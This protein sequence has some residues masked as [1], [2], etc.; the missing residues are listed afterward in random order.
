MGVPY[1]SFVDT[2]A[3]KVTELMVN[4]V[5]YVQAIDKIRNPPNPSQGPADPT[6]SIPIN[7]LPFQLDKN[8][9]GFPVLP[10]PIPSD[11]WK[12][13][14]WDLLFTDY[15]TQ[16]YHLACGGID[17]HIPY[18]RISENQKDFID[19]KYLPQQTSFRAPRNIPIQ[20]MKG[21][22]EHFLQRQRKYGHEDTFK[23]KSIK[24]RGDTVPA[25][26]QANVI[27][28]SPRNDTSIPV[29]GTTSN[30]VSSVGPDPGPESQPPN[31]SN[32]NNNR[33]TS[34]SVGVEE[35][36]RSRARRKP[37][38]RIILSDGESDVGESDV[39]PDL[40][41]DLGTDLGT[42]SRP[43]S[44]SNTINNSSTT[45]P[46]GGEEQSQ[47]RPRPRPRIITRS[48]TKAL[49]PGPPV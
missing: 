35:Q 29:P 7:T 13:T 6:T 12:K 17:K 41:P 30:P 15:L 25:K 47:P 16:I 11:G 48:T 43:P 22:F 18:K 26:Y 14:T 5:E 24:L 33:P 32:T 8:D 20:E 1:T 46:V 45:S 28:E 2:H 36:S 31:N 34:S 40:G 49:G 21:I 9:N 44:N 37:R 3:A 19:P 27:I 23:F 38:L 42:E 10:D 39:G 4:L